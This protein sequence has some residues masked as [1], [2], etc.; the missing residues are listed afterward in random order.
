MT[1]TLEGEVDARA[2]AINT[3]NTYVGVNEAGASTGTGLSAYLV[4]SDGNVG[5]ADSQVANGIA[6]TNRC[7]DQ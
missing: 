1:S 7:C 5:S 4:G 2:T 3:I 6:V